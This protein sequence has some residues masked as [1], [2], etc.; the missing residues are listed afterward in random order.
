M[1]SQ[2]STFE[3]IWICQSDLKFNGR[4]PIKLRRPRSISALLYDHL[5][6]STILLSWFFTVKHRNVPFRYVLLLNQSCWVEI[7]LTTQVI[8]VR[9]I[10]F[11][12][13]LAHH[14]G[15]LPPIIFFCLHDRYGWQSSLLNSNEVLC[16]WFIGALLWLILFR[17][18]MVR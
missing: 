9:F 10:V 2:P 7:I 1:I 18:P 16:L 13:A 12:F 14:F 11:G 6:N 3:E 8:L 17:S 5:H 15:S 4:T